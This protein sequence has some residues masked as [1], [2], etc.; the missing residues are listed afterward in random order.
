VS[1]LVFIPISGP[2]LA[3]RLIQ[4]LIGLVSFG[5]G[6]GLMIQSGLGL[7][8]WDV[9]HQGLSLHFGLTIG[10]WTIIISGVV[11]LAWIPLRERYGIGT[12]L[13]AIIIGVMIDVVGAVVPA[14]TSTVVQWTMLLGGILLVGLASG[15]YIGA[16]LGPG[17][18][19]G[20]MTGIAKKGP[21][22]R[23]TRSVI[24]VSVLIVG[25]LLGGTFGI[26]TIL[27]ALLI[28]PLVQFFLPRWTIDLTP[29]E[30]VWDHPAR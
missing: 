1:A 2:R 18:R 28:G 19:D 6:V 16:N 27:F 10:A 29:G 12:L 14:A 26:G 17:P 3:R 22:I 23:L 4:L 9:L 30:D 25:W 7:S 15:M 11:L 24:E 13:N 20:L 8:P 21:S 5:A